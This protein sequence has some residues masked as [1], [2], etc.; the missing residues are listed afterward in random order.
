MDLT[1]NEKRDLVRLIEN[2]QPIPENYRFK[3]FKKKDEIELLW[4]GKSYD[5]TNVSL[6]FQIIEH[7]DEPR[8]EKKLEIQGS[9]FD[10][11]GRQLKG[12]TNKLIWGNNSLVLS[13]LI[14][15][16]LRKEIEDEGGLKLVYIDPPFDVGDDF[17]FE[18]EIGNKT[19]AKKRNALEQLA[20][21]DTWGKGEDSFLAMIYERIKLIYKLMANNANLVQARQQDMLQNEKNNLEN[22]QEED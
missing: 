5:T 3:L 13:S 18:I 6:P 12:W 4:N 17:E 7:V 22:S 20:F 10:E 16:P 14:N 11:R 8:E 19:L 15:G 1:D 9:L 2:N 21:S